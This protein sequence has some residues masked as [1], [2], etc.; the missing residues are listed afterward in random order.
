M[1]KQTNLAKLHEA[2]ETIDCFSQEGFSR[3]E[4][5]AK[6]VASN[7]EATAIGSPAQRQ[8]II[9]A[10]KAIMYTAVDMG[11][12]INCC[13]EDVGCNYRDYDDTQATRSTSEARHA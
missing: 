2:I 10:L 12:S 13:A 7:I 8:T 11:N 6:L 5:I 3:I 9:T 4:A 1:P